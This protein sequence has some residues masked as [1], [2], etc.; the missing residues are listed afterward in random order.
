MPARSGAP[1][2]SSRWASATTSSPPASKPTAASPPS[3][4]RRHAGRHE[5]HD[6]NEEPAAPGRGGRLRSR[7]RVSSDA[8]G[9]RHWHR[10][11]FVACGCIDSTARDG[12]VSRAVRDELEPSGPGARSATLRITNHRH[13]EACVPRPPRLFDSPSARCGF[14]VLLRTSAMRQR[15]AGGRSLRFSEEFQVHPHVSP[16]SDRVGRANRG[17]EQAEVASN[18]NQCAIH[19]T[20]KNKSSLVRYRNMGATSHGAP[21][22]SGASGNSASRILPG[23]PVLVTFGFGEV[24]VSAIGLACLWKLDRRIREAGWVRLT[25]AIRARPQEALS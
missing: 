1:R 12:N 2:A 21:T 25:C 19:R 17:S 13:T 3:A 7:P 24:A 18:P 5:R 14:A 9:P 22:G 10:P 11:R 15:W 6:T 4:S 20:R 23:C 8:P 16:F